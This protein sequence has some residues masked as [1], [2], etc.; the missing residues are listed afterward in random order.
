MANTEVRL[1]LCVILSTALAAV[2][3]GTSLW[4][5]DVTQQMVHHSRGG[6]MLMTASDPLFPGLP[7]WRFQGQG[8]CLSEQVKAPSDYASLIN[9][10][11]LPK[12]CEM[13]G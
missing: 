11:C 5:L 3:T 13:S 6:G 4:Q 10:A 1:V 9:G 2:S 8:M 12:G 7:A